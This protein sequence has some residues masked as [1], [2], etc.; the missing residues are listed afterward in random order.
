MSVRR[1]ERRGWR[2]RRGGSR[3]E[4]DRKIKRRGKIKSGEGREGNKEGRAIRGER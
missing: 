3:E 1:E 4:G 2:G